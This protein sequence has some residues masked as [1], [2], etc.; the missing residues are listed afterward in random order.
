VFGVL[1]ALFARMKYTHDIY[2]CAFHVSLC[3]PLYDI[4]FIAYVTEK[5]RI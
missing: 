2:Y 1:Y 4:A 3:F 5:L